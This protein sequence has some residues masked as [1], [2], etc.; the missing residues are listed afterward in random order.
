M[1]P[2]IVV[3][4]SVQHPAE[5]HAFQH[6]EQVRIA[7]VEVAI[8]GDRDDA[9]R[10]LVVGRDGRADVDVV[11]ER[12]ERRQGRRCQAATEGQG[13]G[14][15]SA[16]KQGKRERYGKFDFLEHGIPQLDALT[17]YGYCC[18]IEL[19]RRMPDQCRNASLCIYGEIISL[20][21]SLRIAL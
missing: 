7:L 14:A 8:E 3:G 19:A 5:V 18:V 16:G 11:R 6:Q 9:V 20:L 10:E 4:I 21:H 1:V 2:A 17:T 12:P 15:G 13:H